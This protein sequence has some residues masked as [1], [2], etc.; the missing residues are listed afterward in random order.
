MAACIMQP[1]DA[2]LLLGRK[3][4]HG[5]SNTA[6]WTEEISITI[7]ETC[8]DHDYSHAHEVR[9]FLLTRLRSRVDHLK[10]C[11][12]YFKVP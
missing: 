3:L 2:L 5:P 4:V 8:I 9:S 12:G 7:Y 1:T 11:S 10:D 6:S